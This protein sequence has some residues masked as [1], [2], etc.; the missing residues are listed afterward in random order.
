MLYYNTTIETYSLSGTKFGGSNFCHFLFSFNFFPRFRK[1]RFLQ[2]KLPRKFS[3]QKF[4]PLSKIYT[5]TNFCMYCK[6]NVSMSI[7]LKR[8]FRSEAEWNWKRG[9]QRWNDE[10]AV[11]ALQVFGCWEVYR[12]RSSD[13]TSLIYCLHLHACM[14]VTIPIEQD[15]LKIAKSNPQAARTSLSQLQKIRSCETHKITLPQN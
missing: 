8:L 6:N 2:K 5:N 4:I 14:H 1:K 12:K 11:G 3:P 10:I 15:F 13:F 9:I 7:Y